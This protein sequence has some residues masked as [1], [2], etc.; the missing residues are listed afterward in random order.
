MGIKAASGVLSG[1]V[2]VERSAPGYHYHPYPFPPP[3]HLMPVPLS[4]LPSSS[5]SSIKGSSPSSPRSPASP[6]L[7]FFGT[8]L[9]PPTSPQSS[10]PR[11]RFARFFSRPA[12]ASDAQSLSRDNEPGVIAFDPGLRPFAFYLRARHDHFRSTLA[13]LGDID[14]YCSAYL[15]MGFMVRP[16]SMTDLLL[17]RRSPRLTRG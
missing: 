4:I 2:F 6:N 17:C 13:S 5:R 14:E 15:K 12:P 10:T 11:R 8:T 1:R 9:R 7:P 3:A 16:S